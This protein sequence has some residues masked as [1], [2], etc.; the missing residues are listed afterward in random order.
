LTI[1]I[2]FNPTLVRFCPRGTFSLATPVASFNPT[3]VRF[4]RR[5]SVRRLP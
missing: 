1:T 4:C 2:S 3:L 5:G